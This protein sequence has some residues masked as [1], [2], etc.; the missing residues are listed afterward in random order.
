MR[1]VAADVRARQ[2][3]SSRRKWTSSRRESTC[4]LVGVP[5][6]VTRIVCVAIV[7]VLPPVRRLR[8]RARRQH[9]RHLAL[10]FHRSAAIRTATSPAPPVSPLRRSSSHRASSSAGTSRPLSLD[11]R[12]SGGRQR[13]AGALDGAVGASVTCAAAAAVA[14]SPT[15]RSS[16]TYARR[17][18][19]GGSECGSRSRFRP[20]RAPSKRS[21]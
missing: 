12:R 18:S 8:E 14:K 2:A 15:L 10:V 19:A 3:R 13:D 17:R 6:T 11:R 7:S 1:R 9:A 5:F 16:F 4:L 21:P 20:A